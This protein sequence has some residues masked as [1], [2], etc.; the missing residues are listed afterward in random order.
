MASSKGNKPCWARCSLAQFLGF[1]PHLET[2]HIG[3]PY[4][5]SFG[6]R[7]DHLTLQ[8]SCRSPSVPHMEGRRH[9]GSAYQDHAWSVHGVSSHLS[10]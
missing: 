4:E 8:T 10:A 5:S 3:G 6:A 2:L 7:G 9:K 1:T